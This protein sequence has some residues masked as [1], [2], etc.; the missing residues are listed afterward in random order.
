ML[1]AEVRLMKPS[2][3][4]KCLLAAIV[5]VLASCSV[6]V[7]MSRPAMSPAA[8]VTSTPSPIPNGLKPSHGVL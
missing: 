7:T 4:A 5:A 1:S 8:A 3:A 6:A 2:L